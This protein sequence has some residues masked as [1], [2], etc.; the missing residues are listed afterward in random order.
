MRTSYL[1]LAGMIALSGATSTAHAQSNGGGSHTKA[2]HVSTS[3]SKED[4]S[5]PIDFKKAQE[6]S[7]KERINQLTPRDKKLHN[8]EE[9]QPLR[10]T[11]EAANTTIDINN[12]IESHH[13]KHAEIKEDPRIDNLP[14]YSYKSGKYIGFAVHE[15]GNPNSNL[16]GEANYMY[17]HYNSA[18]VHAYV[19]ANEIRQVAPADY[20]S[21]GSGPIGNVY[22]YQAELVHAHSVD[23]F[24]RSV[25]NDA[26]LAA[27]MLKRNELKPQLADN[28]NG[29]GTIISHNAI[30]RYYGGTDHTDPISYFAS[31]N[32][33]MNDYF[34]LVQKHYNQLNNH[35]SKQGQD[36]IKAP[37]KTSTYT[38][39]HGD[40]L[41]DVAK[42]SGTSIEDIKKWNNL[43][44]QVLYSGQVLKLKAPTTNQKSTKI[45]SKV[46][47]VEKNDTLY[48]I[49]QR[50]GVS[51]DQIK[52]YNQLK[53]NNIT[54]GQTLY[55]APTHTVKKGETLYKIASKNH[56]SVSKLKALNG[57]KSNHIKIGDQLLLT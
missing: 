57:L 2:N 44:S 22:Y 3:A 25:N 28:H 9:D 30:S 39:K 45:T 17:G 21:W 29:Q 49:S 38:V 35:T 24:A 42:R 5:Q 6:M 10:V 19:D 31:W 13:L 51:V 23:E 7:P 53:S 48:Q 12:Y 32:Y 4:T 16:S 43:K 40:T 56:V 36:K 47:Q 33:S 26:Y 54:V 14:K 41:Y 52:K 37:I 1:L 8:K 34:K 20:L 15:T 55:L 27:Y 18:F 11:N 46:Y 50:S